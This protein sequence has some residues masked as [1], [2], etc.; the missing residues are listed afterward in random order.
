MFEARGLVYAFPEG[1]PVLKGID[2]DLG[3]GEWLGVAGRS[4]SGKTTLAR[5]LAG[6]LPLSAGT[7]LLDGEP[8][9]ADTRR[10]TERYRSSVQMSFQDPLST[11]P[12]HLPVGVPLRDACRPAGVD[13]AKFLPR[14]LS[15]ME[16]PADVL[17]HRP[18][19]LSG[20]QRQ[21]IALARPLAVN[22]RVLILDELSAALDLITRNR[23]LELLHRISSH[24]GTG[25]LF[26]SHDFDLLLRRC[27]R[28]VVLDNGA[29]V[30]QGKP[31]TL[32]RDSG[33]PLTERFKNS[34]PGT[35][36]R[37][38]RILGGTTAETVPRNRE[39]AVKSEP[40]YYSGIT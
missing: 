30:D 10:G 18:E 6:L 38:R 36:P 7:V 28:I 27:G 31:E 16:L 19:E 33:H 3:P 20:G 39:G 24:R 21:R 25:V 14:L 17:Q 22:P 34:I 15:E 2:L 23:I 37:R 40:D 8:L 26:I 35:H 12:P 9:S 13:P 29:I 5:C 11:L 1:E 4:G 32:V